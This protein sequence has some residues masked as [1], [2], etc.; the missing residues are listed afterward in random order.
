MYR[1]FLNR[2]LELESGGMA[3]I[4]DGGSTSDI[5]NV[6]N[7]SSP[8]AAAVIQNI[9]PA[10][11]ASA[12]AEAIA[13]AITEST[14]TDQAAIY[15]TQ[16]V[17]PSLPPTV[18]PEDIA[19]A[20]VVTSGT[21]Q[22]NLQ[23]MPEG[24]GSYLDGILPKDLATAAG[25]FSATMQQIKNIRNIPIEKFAQVAATLETI[26]G[27]DLVNGT[28][29]PTDTT[30]TEAALTLMALGSGPYGTYTFS[31]FF[32]CMSGLPYPWA[33]IQ[34]AIIGLQSNTLSTVYQN[35]YLALT[36]E[37][38]TA[39]V[40]PGY[41]TSAVSDG[42]GNYNYYYQILS[43]QGISSF[44]GG[45]GYGRNGAA[46]PTATIDG[47]SGATLIT[48][49][50]TTP[51]VNNGSTTFGKVLSGLLGSPGSSVLYGSGVSPT[52]SAPPATLNV[53]I[54][55][56]PALTPDL[57]TVVQ[58]YINAANAE[59]AI[60]RSTH[61]GQSLELNDMWDNLGTQLNIEQRA[62]NA[63]LSIVPNP[64]TDSLFPYPIM[65]YSFTDLVPSYAKL[66]EPN[67]AAQ[68]LEAISDLDI[69]AG[70][71]IVAMMR[72]ERNKARLLE[73]GISTDDVIDDVL[74][75]EE[76]IALISNGTV[77]NSIPAFPFNTEP[78]GYFDPATTNFLV[79]QTPVITS[80]NQAVGP[81]NPTRPFNTTTPTN[82]STNPSQNTI[83]VQP[84]ILGAPSP[85]VA[86]V[87]GIGTPNN[88]PIILAD[89]GIGSPGISAALGGT[90][91][92]VAGTGAGTGA[93]AG[94]GGSL[95]APE[96]FAGPGA[97]GG[98]GAQGGGPIVPGSLAG[99]PYTKLIPPALN[100]IYT[101][102]VL[103]PAS[104]PVQA[105]IE[106]VIKCNCD[107]WIQ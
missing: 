76:Q 40:T 58:A 16:L 29:V 36:W 11:E 96:F 26:R 93:G 94:G 106:E 66:T 68:T 43:I 52:P 104:L 61:P 79:T 33:K 7:I 107:C 27:L 74:P 2:R 1:D 78:A 30:E 73:A 9:S 57:D 84:S 70:Q 85:I 89:I 38:A 77:A 32:G 41:S 65:V 12:Q 47:G 64:R 28:N 56:P 88:T 71:S 4:T 19:A 92:N 91:N 97:G 48:T 31:D 22:V 8:E 53:T 69:N 95:I 80:P 35:L 39:S 14:I 10:I 20:A 23:I 34:S 102:G 5:N 101:S 100:P 86:A 49:I 62:R 17:A 67:M 63:G 50:D 44:T 51:A 59:I 3:G 99:S 54:Q 90:V 75:L 46:A 98:L 25:A 55:A 24:F 15:S 6:P 21:L 18:Q 87:L 105:A 81:N 42:F 72:A 60:I 103:L 82:P 13:V 83:A 37:Q 45:G